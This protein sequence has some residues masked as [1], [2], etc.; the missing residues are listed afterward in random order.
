MQ[1]GYF[2]APSDCSFRSTEVSAQEVTTKLV[3]RRLGLQPAP[4]VNEHHAH[5]DIAIAAN[6]YANQI[7]LRSATG[8]QANSLAVD[9]FEMLRDGVEQVRARISEM[10][11]SPSVDLL[12]PDMS[13]ATFSAINT[14]TKKY[15][16]GNCFEYSCLALEYIYHNHPEVDAEIFDIH[17]GD[18]VFVVIGRDKSTDAELTD[19][20]T[21]GHAAYICDPWMNS[22]FPAADYKTRL[23]NFSHRVQNGKGVNIVES[24]EEHHLLIP[25]KHPYNTKYL[26]QQETAEYKQI[27]L[28]MFQYKLAV[29]KKHLG[30]LGKMANQQKQIPLAT[31]CA[32]WQQ[33]LMEISR[34]DVKLDSSC[35]M[36]REQ[37]V[38]VITKKIA[39][40][41]SLIAQTKSHSA[42]TS[43]QQRKL[44]HIKKSMEDE[45]SYRVSVDRVRGDFVIEPELSKQIVFTR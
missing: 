4:V 15:S 10:R 42:F 44:Q 36:L 35:E 41:A 3:L 34:Q 18:H 9:R 24:L 21:W 14:L 1:S 5:A 45:L 12:D 31:R 27:L 22:V 11:C 37:L 30:S 2:P 7:I 43:K 40:V 25:Y 19:P 33:Q 32:Q 8:L 38:P 16:I 6:R 39:Q 29:L 13:I 26:F 28:S 17:E 20:T 23:K